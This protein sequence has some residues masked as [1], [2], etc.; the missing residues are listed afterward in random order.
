MK[1]NLDTLFKTNLSYESEGVWF[2][3]NEQT[4]FR[5]RRFGGANSNKVKMALAKYHKPYAKQVDAGTLSIEKEKEIMIRTFVDS[6]MVEWKGVEIDGVDTQ[7]SPE[8]AVKLFI[9]IPELFQTLFS[10]ASD[11]S[12]YKDAL[13]NS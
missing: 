12:T 6:S 11:I 5:V 1:T 3:I 13:G 8:A 10:Y 9:G 4:S 2:D 7:Y